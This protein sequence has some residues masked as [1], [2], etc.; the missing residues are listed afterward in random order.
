MLYG[1]V[2]LYYI[3]IVDIDGAIGRRLKRGM[4]MKLLGVGRV[5]FA[6]VNE[7]CSIP[8]STCSGIGVNITWSKRISPATLIVDH[9]SYVSDV[10]NAYLVSNDYS[11]DFPIHK[12]R[13]QRL[14]YGTTPNSNSN[15]IGGSANIPWST[16]YEG[17]EPNFIDNEIIS[18]LN[19]NGNRNS[20]TNSI[21]YR[22]A[23]WNVVGRSD[24]T[25]LVCQVPPPCPFTM[26]HFESEAGVTDTSEHSSDVNRRTSSRMVSDVNARPPSHAVAYPGSTGGFAAEYSET[27]PVIVQMAWYIRIW[28]LFTSL[29]NNI[30]ILYILLSGIVTFVGYLMNIQFYLRRQYAN[31]PTSGVAAP[32]LHEQYPRLYGMYLLAI[33]TS[34]KIATYCLDLVKKRHALYWNGYME[35]FLAYLVKELNEIECQ[36]KQEG[37]VTAG[38]VASGVVAA[39]ASESGKGDRRTMLQQNRQVSVRSN[40]SEL[41]SAHTSTTNSLG[42][43]TNDMHENVCDVC[44]EPYMKY[45]KLHHCSYCW[46]SF[47]GDKCGY[48]DS[49]RYSLVCQIKGGCACVDCQ[50]ERGVS[51]GDKPKPQ[52]TKK[53]KSKM[54]VFMN[55]MEGMAKPTNSRVTSAP[56]PVTSNCTSVTPIHPDQ[57]EC[58]DGLMNNRLDDIIAVP[59]VKFVRS[60]SEPSN[61]TTGRN[62]AVDRGQKEPNSREVASNSQ[63]VSAPAI[64]TSSQKQKT[65][66]SVLRDN[67]K[68]SGDIHDDNSSK[69]SPTLRAWEVNAKKGKSSDVVPLSAVLAS[70]PPMPGDEGKSNNSNHKDTSSVS[71]SG[72]TS[73]SQGGDKVKKKRNIMQK[74][75]SRFRKKGSI[76][77]NSAPSST[78]LIDALEVSSA[79]STK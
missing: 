35:T 19:L 51:N 74:I 61:K 15:N 3:G 43:T 79:G 72:V 26:S 56:L 37:T 5:P 22:I 78:L 33:K 10:T 76:E 47:C 70:P 21:L 16:I 8:H 73:Q 17:M 41:S 30:Y 75:A 38:G 67:V 23:A 42:A 13:L 54:N 7:I 1:H 36:N 25:M 53:L 9:N 31:D 44:H 18:I 58:A 46:K 62:A 2:I 20:N 34:L 28:N 27:T 45:R 63:N 12:Y 60:S 4:R 71:E 64:D 50:N 6:P 77:N 68:S 24:Y 59:C 11:D 55:L 40:G 52:E 69:L 57:E 39:G 66:V 48:I 32:G 14:N 65:V 49:C 29:L